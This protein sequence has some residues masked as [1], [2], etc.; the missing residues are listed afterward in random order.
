MIKVGICGFGYW[1]PNLFRNFNAHPGFQVTAIAD[2]KDANRVKA[3]MLDPHLRVYDDAHDL[4]EDPKIEAVAIATPVGTHFELTW[5]ALSRFKH[6]LVEKPMCVSTEQGA[7]LM[8]LASRTRRTLMVNH[9]YLFHGVV[10]KLAELKSDGA[11]GEVSYF[12][13]VR[14]NLGLFQPDMNVLWDLAPHDFSIMDY[15]FD[16]EP[17]HV[18]A[19]GYCHVNQHLPDITYITMHF[20][21]QMIAH[22]HLSWMSPVKVRRISI[23]GSKQMAVW[24]DLNPEE[25]LKIY[26]TGIDLQPED[27]RSVIVPSYRIGDIYSPRISSQ[28]PLAGVIEHFWNVIRGKED[29]LVG[30]R[31]GLRVIQMLEMSQGALNASLDQ[32]HA[33]NQSLGQGRQAL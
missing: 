9:T 32:I 31:Q 4:I 26:D 10:R 13:S 29:T 22:F 11:L 18:E 17:I 28:E 20:R 3:R 27:E 19:T 25:K 21:S 8:E 1:G 30:G 7:D 33:R 2:L 5:R 14:I 6:V 15:L 24:D 23:G 12:D 16:E